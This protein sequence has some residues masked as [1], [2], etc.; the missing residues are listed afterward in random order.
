MRSTRIGCAGRP[1]CYTRRDLDL[2]IAAAVEPEEASARQE[3]HSMNDEARGT[4]GL[5]PV[6]RRGRRG[7]GPGG[8]GG[9]RMAIRVTTAPGSTGPGGRPMRRSISAPTIAACWSRARPATASASSTPSPASSGWAKGCRPPAA[10]SE[11]AIA[12]AVDALGICRDKMRNRGVTRAR[13]IATEACRAAANGAD[14]LARVRERGRAR[15]RD[16]RPRDRGR[17]RR[18]RLHAADRSAGRAA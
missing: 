10:S 17:A 11:A 4:G 15:A 8:G 1:H 13:L 14:F 12:R 7:S 18:D 9:R 5:D 3:G 16:R 2:D 6:P